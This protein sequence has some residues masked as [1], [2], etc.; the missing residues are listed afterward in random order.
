MVL[1]DSE[2]DK[3]HNPHYARRNQGPMSIPISPGYRALFSP[4]PG[5]CYPGQT[6][7]P[8]ARTRDQPRYEIEDE[9]PDLHLG[10]HTQTLAQ[11]AGRA[12]RGSKRRGKQPDTMQEMPQTKVVISEAYL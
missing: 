11:I 3:G 8:A 1:F 5:I 7:T 4:V 6:S 10:L 2:L 12:H 9:G